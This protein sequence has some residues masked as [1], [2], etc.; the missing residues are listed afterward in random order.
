MNSTLEMQFWQQL[1]KHE[2]WPESNQVL[3][4]KENKVLQSSTRGESSLSAFLEGSYFNV[5]NKF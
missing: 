1:E 2:L 4:W 5:K 3:W